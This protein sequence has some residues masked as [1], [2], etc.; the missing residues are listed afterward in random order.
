MGELAPGDQ[1]KEVLLA[2]RLGISRAPVR[3]AL[4]ILIREGL[5][6]SEPQRG[7]FIR[8]LSPTEIRDSYFISGV[9]EWAAVAVSLERFT[10]EDHARLDTLLV[11]MHETA[12]TASSMLDFSELDNS[13]HSLLLSRAGNPQ[14]VDL[15]RRSCLNIAKFLFYNY[16][17]TLFTSEEFCDRHEK[18]MAA[19]KEGNPAVVEQTIRAH[20]RETGER[21]ARYG[22]P[23]KAY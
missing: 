4:H 17:G 5:I 2:E 3:E 21:M 1:V 18:I 19:V 11:R 7:K 15:A 14:L 9:L 20:Y 16:W 23:H 13:F 6:R 22:I 12:L 8:E 10:A